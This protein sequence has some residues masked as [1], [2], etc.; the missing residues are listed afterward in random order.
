[1]SYRLYGFNQDA[2]LS[3]R[4]K[5]GSGVIK[6]DCTDLLL[7]KWL[8]DNY[9]PGVPVEIDLN[10]FIEDYPI[11]NLTIHT[12]RKRLSKLVKLEI[13][14]VYDQHID[15]SQIVNVLKNKKMK[16]L[17]YGSLTCT[18]C[19]VNT[20]VLHEHHYPIPKSKGGTKTVSI[21]PNCHYE[22]HSL[23]CSQKYILNNKAAG[24][25]ME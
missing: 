20:V 9:R 18:W 17:G 4:K 8:F 21:C 15:K 23:E 10:V 25:L 19:G 16:G 14:E 11:S 5:L 24:A 7:L 13:L 2:A 1:M 3:F 6:L 12:A 22:F